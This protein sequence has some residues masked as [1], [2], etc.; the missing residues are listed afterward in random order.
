MKDFWFNLFQCCYFFFSGVYFFIQTF[1]QTFYW[2][3]L[4]CWMENGIYWKT[5]KYFLNLISDMLYFFMEFQEFCLNYPFTFKWNLHIQWFTIYLEL[6]RWAIFSFVFLLIEN[7]K[8]FRPVYRLYF[9]LFY[10]KIEFHY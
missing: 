3:Q 9:L 6:Q 7:I 1:W 8:Y 2:F 4:F 10:F 5:M